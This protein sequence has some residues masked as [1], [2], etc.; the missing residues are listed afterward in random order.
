MLNRSTLLKSVLLCAIL[1]AAFWI[2]IQSVDTIPE[3]HFTSVDAYVYYWQ[4]SLISEHRQLHARDM[5][6]WLPLGRDLGQTLNLYGYALAY[7]H[8]A[9]AWLF[10]SITLYD[11]A[12]YMPVVYFCIGLGALYLFL[13]NACG[14]LSASLVGV[15]LATLPGS[16]N[17][18]HCGIQRPRRFLP[19][20][21]SPRGDNLPRLSTSRHITETPVLDTRQRLYCLSW[22][23]VLGRLW[24]VPGCHY[25][26]G[27]LPLSVYRNRGWA[28][29]LCLV[30]VLFCADP[31]PR[32]SSI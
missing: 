17:K 19:H 5:H 1:C 6:R 8:K 13:A 2:R 16:I 10:P 15:L 25:C 23:S 29:T 28:R 12:L 24:R 20:A 14:L 22:R 32:L 31:L 27:N 11:I 21:R 7:T 26:C 3:G 4:A 18:K 30:G 9:V